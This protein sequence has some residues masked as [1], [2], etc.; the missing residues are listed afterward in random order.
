MK[1]RMTEMMDRNAP[2]IRTTTEDWNPEEMLRITLKFANLF[3]GLTT[4]FSNRFFFS[5][6]FSSNRKYE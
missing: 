6:I 3:K 1:P 2:I 5:D 4:I